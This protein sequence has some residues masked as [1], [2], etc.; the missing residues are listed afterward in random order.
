MSATRRDIRLV[1]YGLTPA[2]LRAGRADLMPEPEIRRHSSNGAPGVISLI[3]VKYTTARRAAEEAVDAVSA[4]IGGRHRP[5]RTATTSLPYAGI[6]DVEGRLLET[7]RDL[8]LEVDRDVVEHLA[9]WYGTEASDLIRFAAGRNALERL[10]KDAPVLT[11]EI[12]YAAEH[13]RAWRLGDAVLRRTPLGSA[14]HPGLAAL[15]CAAR[16]MA[17]S[18]G[19]DA[20]RVAE[21]IAAVERLYPVPI[22]P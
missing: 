5:S 19:W 18:K 12:L 14:G 11:G 4:E 22:A 21:E 7:L 15:E 3:G 1:H 10:T 13:A 9:G 17:A 16:V 8:G 20:T 2:I 6:A